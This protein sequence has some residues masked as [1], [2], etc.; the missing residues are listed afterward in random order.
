MDT[1]I[2]MSGARRVAHRLALWLP[3]A[4]LAFGLSGARAADDLKV[5]E[6]KLAKAD[7]V[8][9]GDAKCTACHDETE[10]YPVLAIGKTKH[11]T[12]V[13]GRTPTCVSCHGTSENHMRKLEGQKDRPK[14]DISFG[15][16]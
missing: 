3:T 4:L 13:D 12:V 15:G 2:G 1:G 6:F 9:R 10:K 11:G 8:L 14:P 16:Q 7:T 5:G